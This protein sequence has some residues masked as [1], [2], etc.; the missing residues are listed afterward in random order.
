MGSDIII[1]SDA[2][3]TGIRQA[4]QL[5]VAI[6]NSLEDRI[7]PGIST[8]LIDQWC[9][10]QIEAAGAISAA[11]NYQPA[12]EQKPFPNSV[13]TSVN[14][15]ICHGIPSHEKQLRDGDI[16]NVDVTVVL[17][18]YY[19][20]SSRMYLVGNPGTLPRSLC[21]GAHNCLMRGIEAVVPGERFASIGAAIQEEAD[22]CGYSVVRE[23]CGHGTGLE[24]HEPPQILHY[25][26]SRS[27]Q[28]IK[29]N[30]VFT[31]EPMINAGE[32]HTRLLADGWTVVTKDRSLS[33]QW[34]HTV[35]VTETG[36]EI[37][38][39]NGKA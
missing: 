13:C 9:A 2:Q 12:A 36:A 27:M 32:R 38:T 39:A 28:I 26:N 1:K 37:L 18:G 15:T 17:D 35:V 8:G 20:D 7:K 29:P 14:H 3:I 25:R 5:T 33:A 11:L 30:M 16:V 22:Q 10:E 31:I 23:Y 34:E 21:T 4:C 19:G 24:F 6:L